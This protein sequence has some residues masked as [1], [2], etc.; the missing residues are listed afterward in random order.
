M[1]T[2]ICERVADIKTRAQAMKCLT[3][4]S[5]AVGPGFVFERVSVV[6]CHILNLWGAFFICLAWNWS[7]ICFSFL[8]FPY[9]CPRLWKNTRIL[10]FLVRACCGWFLQLKTLVS[11]TWNWRL[12]FVC[13]CD[14]IEIEVIVLSDFSSVPA[15]YVFW[16]RT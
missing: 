3:T 2:G 8:F 12:F 9:R 5:E 1:L 16:H 14:K 6:K 13:L 4:F 10:R 7:Y 15:A 11:H